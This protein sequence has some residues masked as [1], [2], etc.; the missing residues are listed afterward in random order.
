MLRSYKWDEVKTQFSWKGAAI[1]RGHQH[2]RKGIALFGAI[3]RQLLVK[4]LQPEKTSLCALVI[5]KMWSSLMV[6]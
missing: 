4:T 1:Q 6:L 3:T 5:Y 2:R